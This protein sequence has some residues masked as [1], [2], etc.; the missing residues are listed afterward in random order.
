MT[1]R[2]LVR[3][4]TVHYR[5]GEVTLFSW[6]A[7]F[8]ILQ[9]HFSELPDDPRETPPPFGN[10]G[11]E[12]VGAVVMSHPIRESL[13]RLTVL[14]DHIRYVRQEYER[15]CVDF[16]RTFAEYLQTFSSKT[17]ATLTRKVRKFA[18]FSG[19]RTDWREYRSPEQMSEFHRMARELSRRTYQEKLL[20]AGLPAGAAFEHEMKTLAEQGSVR[21]YLLF[22]DATPVAY[23]YSPIVDGV[24]CYQFLGF[25]PA[26][27]E[28]SPGTVLQYHIFERLFAEKGLRMFDFLEGEGQHKRLFATRTTR[29]ADIYYYRRG[30]KNRTLVSLHAN[31]DTLSTYIGELLD[32]YNLKSRIKRLLRSR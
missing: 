12:V 1:R 29:C 4:F 14:D 13:P 11:P 32:R 31:L 16:G 20:D 22:H 21:G 7:P 19:G 27:R 2:W 8:A 28:H 15:C 3:P 6:T 9:A 5:I 24:V 18:E 23:L 25:D 10:F 17:R 26:F 30:L